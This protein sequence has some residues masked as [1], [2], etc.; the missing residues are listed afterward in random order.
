MVA[1]PFSEASMT[2]LQLS[3]QQ[4]IQRVGAR[5]YNHAYALARFSVRQD[6]R[7]VGLDKIRTAIAKEAALRAT[8]FAARPFLLPHN[9]GRAD[10]DIQQIAE[11]ALDRAAL[12]AREEML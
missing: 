12:Y 7:L 5:T 8:G 1:L 2:T 4:H 3:A 10:Q 6:R 9:A 11:Q